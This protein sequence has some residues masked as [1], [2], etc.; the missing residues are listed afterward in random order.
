MKKKQDKK[1]NQYKLSI[2]IV[3]MNNIELNRNCLKSIFRYTKMIDFKVFVLDNNSTDGTIEMIKKEFPQVELIESKKCKGFTYN[4]NQI[5]RRVQSE[6]V[7]VLNNDTEFTDNSIKMMTDFLDNH[8]EAGAVGCRI[9]NKDGSFQFTCIRCD[10]DLLTMFSIKTG[11]EKLFPKSRIWGR[12]HMGYADKNKIQE[13]EVYSGSCVMIRKKVMDDIG[14]LDENI[15][16]GP[17]DYDYSYRIRNQGWKIYYLPN[18]SVIHLHHQTIKTLSLGLLEEVKGIFYL[19]LKHYGKFKTIIFKGLM[20]YGAFLKYFYW[21]YLFISKKNNIN[22]FKNNLEI[23]GKLIK[24][25]IFYPLKTT[26]RRN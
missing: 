12:P 5:L 25:V 8:S 10:Y 2:S 3:T 26:G 17:D 6:Y 16:L 4:Q 24:L 15:S 7:L 23:H 21:I 18:A 1:N 14:L 11:M 20:L 19:Y 22:E 9:L 13:I